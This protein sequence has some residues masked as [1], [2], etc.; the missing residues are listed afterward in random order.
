[1]VLGKAIHAVEHP[2]HVVIPFRQR[3]R[4]IRRGQAF[5][6]Q[7][8]SPSYGGASRSSRAQ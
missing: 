5:L 3:D 2:F 6:A 4:Q 1:L 8:N 7:K